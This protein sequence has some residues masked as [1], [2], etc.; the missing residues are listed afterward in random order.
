MY[1]FYVFPYPYYFEFPKIIFPVIFLLIN[2]FL[3][4][5]CQNWWVRSTF[6]FISKAGTL[7]VSSFKILSFFETWGTFSVSL[8]L[9]LAP[10]SSPAHSQP[11]TIPLC[12]CS[13]PSTT[14]ILSVIGTW[15]AALVHAVPASQ[16]LLPPTA[17]SLFI[18][19]RSVVL[20]CVR[21]CEGP[22]PPG[23]M[24]Q[25]LEALLL[26]FLQYS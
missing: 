7:S 9:S 26:A 19:Y 14:Q 10:T 3:T 16:P 24:W 15:H 6:H 2:D 20:K 17:V 8:L 23:D 5:K 22:V 1:L 21:V 25:C 13:V 18:L 12:S 4:S 11:H